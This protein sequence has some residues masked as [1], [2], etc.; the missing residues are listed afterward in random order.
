M[1]DLTKNFSRYEFACKCGCGQDTVDFELV[2]VMQ[3]LRDHFERTVHITSANRCRKHNREVGGSNTSQHLYG[4]AADF[5][6]DGV[7]NDDI[8]EYLQMS[9]LNK[10]GIGRYDNFT[11]IDTRLKKARWDLRG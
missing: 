3:R 10:Y 4:R 8:Q 9:F 5:I 6:I 2:N 7:Y 11:H 1:G